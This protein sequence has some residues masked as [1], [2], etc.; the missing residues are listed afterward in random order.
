MRNNSAGFEKIK[1]F[2]QNKY[3]QK[4]VFLLLL[5]L[6]KL[7]L[8]DFTTFF[9]IKSVVECPSLEKLDIAITIMYHNQVMGKQY[10]Q[11]VNVPFYLNYLSICH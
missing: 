6:V 5:A 9:N 8:G 4:G 7:F 3:V 11:L 1:T 10:V 2:W